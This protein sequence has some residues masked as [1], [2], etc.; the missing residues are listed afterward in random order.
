[1][2]LVICGKSA[3]GKDT[4][5][6]KLVEEYGYKRIVTYTTR[7][8]RAG[9]IPEETYHY[10]MD[11]D[12]QE[13]I[14]VGFFAEWRAYN[15]ISGTWY[16]GSAKED[17]ECDGK[18]VIILTPSG[19]REAR[20]KI[21]GK[22]RCIYLYADIETILSRLSNRNDKNDDIRRRVESDNRDFAGFESAADKIIYNEWNDS[23]DDV[24][25]KI[26]DFVEIQK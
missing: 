14:N 7:P 1:M 8:P 24:C 25:K 19:Y 13:K 22:I 18:N 9:E 3:S 12:F 17:Y 4:V 26:N 2:I 20:D 23:I 15:T 5:A 6:K 21:N 16:Y 10:I 11:Q